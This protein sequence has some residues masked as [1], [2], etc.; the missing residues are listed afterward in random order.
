MKR[1]HVHLAVSDLAESMNFYNQ[2]FGKQPDVEHADYAKWLLDD[3]RINFAISARGHVTGVNHMGF[4]AES[5]AD[6]AEL[7]ERAEAAAGEAVFNEGATTCCY[8]QSEKHWTVDPSGL[9]W[10]HYQTMGQ[11]ESFGLPKSSGAEEGACCV[12][13]TASKRELC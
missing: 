8:A 6:L 11:I 5:A 2:L 12:P 10:E 7:K 4:Q 13:D 3:P 9:A 1:F